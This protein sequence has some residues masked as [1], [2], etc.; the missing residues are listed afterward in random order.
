MDKNTIIHIGSEIVI[1]SVLTY[2]IYRK[3]SEL[4]DRCNVLEK[5]YSDLERKFVEISIRCDIMASIITNG[6]TASIDSSV[7][8]I[9]KRMSTEISSSAIENNPSSK[10]Q[11]TSNP[12]NLSNL[13]EIGKHLI[14]TRESSKDSS[15]DPSK[16]PPSKESNTQLTPSTKETDRL[17]KLKKKQQEMNIG[18]DSLD[19]IDK[20]LEADSKSSIKDSTPIE[21]PSK[22]N[23]N[24]KLK[25]TSHIEQDIKSSKL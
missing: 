6:N 19:I 7:S 17:L 22:Q 4:Q 11:E 21:Q 16:I 8:Q 14:S 12:L 15:K 23:T 1:I 24:P 20:V 3:Y 10:K 18:S 13:L 5:K 2:I 9:M 25:I